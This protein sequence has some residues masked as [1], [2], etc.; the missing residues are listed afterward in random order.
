MAAKDGTACGNWDVFRMKASGPSEI[1]RAPTMTDDE[2][3][4]A[5]LVNAVVI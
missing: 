1:G 4:V 5:G 3:S 2:A